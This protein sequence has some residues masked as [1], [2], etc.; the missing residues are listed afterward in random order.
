MQFLG[1]SRFFAI[2][3]DFRD[4]SRFFKFFRDFSRF[5]VNFRNFSSFFAIFQDFSRFL[6]NFQNSSSFFA[7]FREFSK[8]F[9][10]F[11]DFC[12]FR[13]RLNDSTSVSSPFEINILATV[14]FRG[15][16]CGYS[17]MKD[18]CGTM[19]FSHC[20]SKNGYQKLQ[21]RI[22]DASKA[23]FEQV[24]KKS[25][26]TIFDVYG[27]QGILPDEDGILDIGVSF[28]G[29][30]QKRG[31]SSH[32]GLAS[33]IDLETGL[34]IDFEVLSNFCIKCKIAEDAEQIEGWAEKHAANCSKNFN[35]SSNGI[36]M[37][38]AK[39]LWRR[40]IEKHKLRYVAM[41]RDGDSKSFQAVSDLQV[42]GEEKEITKEDCINHVSKRMGTA[43][44]KLIDTSKA[45][46]SPISG[47]GKVT[48]DMVLRIQNYYGKAV[49]ELSDDVPLL[50]KRIFAI[51]FHLA[52]SDA[53][54]KHGHCPPGATS[55]CFWQRDLAKGNS[56]RSHKAHATLSSDVEKKMVSVFQRLANED[57]LKRCSRASTQN[58]NESFHNVVWRICPKIGYVGRH[59]LETAVSMAACQFSMGATF[60]TVLCQCLG[61]EAGVH[62]KKASAIKSLQRLE[63][64]KKAS[65]KKAKTRR[66][67][68]KYKGIS[69]E[70]QKKRQEGDTYSAGDFV[71]TMATL[72]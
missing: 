66:K 55:W 31:H 21:K 15:I 72:F 25:V 10:F 13:K 28:D 1:F 42:Y 64:A 5:F 49:K 19:N 30:W 29:S 50:K 14:A 46:G 34:L 68:L 18:W 54:P 32:N 52:S 44:R 53:N 51:L 9:K 43:L 26:E 36:E 48:K 8:F 38:C 60:K 70:V 12:D 17:A 11:C 67:R 41:L 35:G 59:T 62:T 22:N 47:K 20:L 37:E 58:T 6:A 4:F 65:N 45:E 2:L 39:R 23:A 27:K 24:S 16:G 69:K 61:I 3:R 63:I 40:S 71:W 56:S 33:V 57:L 7:I